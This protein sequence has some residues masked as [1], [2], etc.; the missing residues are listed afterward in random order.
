VVRPR[1]LAPL[2][3]GVRVVVSAEGVFLVAATFQSQGELEEARGAYVACLNSGDIEWAPRAAVALGNLLRSTDRAR[4][5]D[6]LR[7][8]MDS[9]H[10]QWAPLA[11]AHLGVLLS[12]DGDTEGARVAYQFASESLHADIAPTAAMNLGVLLAAQGDV[13]GARAAYQRAIDSKHPDEAPR[14]AVNLGFL[15]AESDMSASSEAFR[16]AIASEHPEQRPLGAMNMA[17]LLLRQGDVAGARAY[18]TIGIESGHPEWSRQCADSLKKLPPFDFLVRTVWDLIAA[19]AVKLAERGDTHNA[20]ALLR[21]CVRHGDRRSA[22]NAALNLGL[23]LLT[24]G[25]LD[26]ADAAFARGLTSD[27]PE[28]VARSGLNLGKMRAARNNTEGALAALQS[29]VDAGPS[30][31]RPVAQVCVG[32]LLEANDELH[33]ARGLYELAAK[34]GD[35]VIADQAKARLQSL[36][37][38]IMNL[39]P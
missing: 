11:A 3:E 10:A 7:L 1:R 6:Y 30:S 13:E 36:D 19:L 12:E 26:G 4:A 38:K 22:A 31:W 5:R 18:L 21:D 27:E 39:K 24:Q 29:A 14:A 25:D 33:R 37:R 28:V 8:G 23:L 9:A 34:S 17:A 15:L 20:E 16:F 32:V 35:R 2:R